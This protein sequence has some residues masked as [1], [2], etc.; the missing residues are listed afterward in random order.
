MILPAGGV[1]TSQPANQ[2][3]VASQAPIP[4]IAVPPADGEVLRGD[5]VTRYVD[6]ARR[7]TDDFAPV[8]QLVMPF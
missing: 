1:P 8:D 4:K 5:A 7:L 2:V 3:L 6:G